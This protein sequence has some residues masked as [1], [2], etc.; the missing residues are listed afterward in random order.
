MTHGVRT[1]DELEPLPADMDGHWIS[2]PAGIPHLVR[3]T[4]AGKR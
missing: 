2:N 4:Q 1:Q 3:R